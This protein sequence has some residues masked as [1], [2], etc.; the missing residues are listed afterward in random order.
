M[1]QAEQAE[2]AP[3]SG[4]G[5]KK[6]TPL[7]F[8][9]MCKPWFRAISKYVDPYF[10][11]RQGL[12]SA[13][14]HSPVVTDELIDRYYELALREGSREATLSR[15]AGPRP[16]R[17]P[18]DPSLFTQPTLIMWGREDALISVDL[19]ISLPQHCPMQPWLSTTT[20]ATYPWKKYR[21]N[22]PLILEP[23]CKA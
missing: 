23:F 16:T 20:W 14:N 18:V 4:A 10:I 15:F 19:P 12:E 1:Q 6:E 8:Q 22:L 7:F 2:Q 5:K 3:E 11:T 17:E 9:L 13:Y 21:R